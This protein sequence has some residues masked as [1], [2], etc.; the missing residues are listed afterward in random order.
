MNDMKAFEG[1]IAGVIQGVV[2]PPRPVDAMAVA[3]SAATQSPKWRFQTMFS[4]T[5]FVVAGAIV[6][7]FGGVLLVSQPFDQ[8]GAGVPGAAQTDETMAPVFVTGSTKAETGLFRT[9]F[10]TD[11]GLMQPEGAGAGLI[12]ATDPRLEGVLIVMCSEMAIDEETQVFSAT[13]IV[14]N[15]GG[16]WLGT[17]IGGLGDKDNPAGCIWAFNGYWTAVLTGEDGYE[18]LTAFLSGEGK[19]GT[20]DENDFRG[21]IFRGDMPA[22]PEEFCEVALDDSRVQAFEGV[23]PWL[24][25]GTKLACSPV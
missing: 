19:G 20:P 2:G 1:Q 21:V 15:D 18:G 4:A 22:I 12:H 17:A 5:K 10:E 11:E 23:H 14:Q 9:V 13:T 24:E 3:R 6:A 8:Q 16:R 25:Q 7:L